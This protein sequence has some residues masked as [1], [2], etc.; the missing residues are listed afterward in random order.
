MKGGIDQDLMLL[1]MIAFAGATVGCEPFVVM[2]K[3][4]HCVEFPDLQSLP[5]GPFAVHDSYPMPL[6]VAIHSLGASLHLKR[7]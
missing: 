2:E 6:V 1:C 4:D 5:E 3:P 7:R